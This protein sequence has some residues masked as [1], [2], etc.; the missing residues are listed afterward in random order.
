MTEAVLLAHALVARTAEDV[1]ARILFI[2]GPTA[3]AVRARPARLS[4]DVD[5]LVDPVAFEEVCHAI[6]DIGWRRR[7]TQRQI[8]RAADLAFDHS[9]HFIHTE[10]PCD[11]DVHFNFPGFLAADQ[12]VFEALWQRRILVPIAGTKVPA[13]DFTGQSLVVALHALRDP[14]NHSNTE[15]LKYLSI[16]LGGAHPELAQEV[17]ELAA[18]TGSSESAHQFLVSIGAAQSTPEIA[19]D[20]LA[21]WQFRQQTSGLS[22][23]LWLAELRRTPWAQRPKLALGALLP[24]REF[25]AGSHLASD[26]TR[27]QV[28]AL[29]LRR[30]Q[31]GLRATPAALRSRHLDS[32]A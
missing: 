28:A 32:G 13:P 19:S 1:G 18:A 3:V 15:D 14:E 9:T 12:D 2:K 6:E 24:R 26:L 20:R 23:A 21:A 29:H 31:R 27:R 25:L 4:T 8:S 17:G 5:V 7:F 11:L 10:W 30:W 22:G 16:R